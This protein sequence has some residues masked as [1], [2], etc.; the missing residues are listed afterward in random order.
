MT[1]D[2]ISQQIKLKDGRSLGYA[3]YGSPD[4][5]PIFYFH[6]FPGSRIDWLLCDAANSAA[7]LRGLKDKQVFSMIDAAL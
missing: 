1:T 3:E 6:G 4:G 2:R 5:K 7:K